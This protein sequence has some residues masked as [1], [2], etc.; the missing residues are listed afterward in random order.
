[1]Q[2]YNPLSIK[3]QQVRWIQSTWTHYLSWSVL[4]CFNLELSLML[5]SKFNTNSSNHWENH[6]GYWNLF[7]GNFWVILVFFAPIKTK[8]KFLRCV[9]LLNNYRFLKT[10]LSILHDTLHSYKKKKVGQNSENNL[11]QNSEEKK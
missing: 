9:F 4:T 3:T 6:C 11:N 2:L 5:C 7:L 10:V 8:H 1:M